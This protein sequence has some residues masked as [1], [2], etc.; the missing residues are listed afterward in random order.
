MPM[1]PTV[2]NLTLS[3]PK[4]VQAAEACIAFYAAENASQE[5]VPWASQFEYGHWA[6]Y[7]W[8]IIVGV[9]FVYHVFNMIKDRR[10][11]ST[12]EIGQK[13]G[14]LRKIQAAGRMV[15]YRRLPTNRIS[16]LL[17]ASP[18]Y[19]VLA[20]LLITLVFLIGLTFAQ[21]P[22]YRDH[23]GYGS[24]PIAIRTGL[25]A[26]ACVPILVALAGKAN[27]ITLFTGL[28][29]ERLNVVHRWV[30]WMSLG[31]S[32]IHAI[33]FFIA[34]YRDIGNGG[35]QRIVKE[36][37]AGGFSGCNQVRANSKTCHENP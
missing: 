12:P 31:L 17:D 20:F 4:C 34:S 23:L 1:D 10:Y 11:L 37:Y 6:T 3:D 27:I 32:F 15:F 13:P 16:K 14:L 36:F 25:M 30:A 19:G 22:Y 33:P 29:H 18:N 21:R 26:T 8:V 5:A 9:L 28:S 2:A 35:Y 24:P 7:Y